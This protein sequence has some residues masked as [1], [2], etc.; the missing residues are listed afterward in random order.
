MKIRELFANI[1]QMRPNAFT[2]REKLYFLNT[3]EGRI[4]KEILQKAEGD[5]SVFQVFQE[6]EEEREL[7]VPIPY[8]DIYLYYLAAMIDFYNGDSSRYN[9]TMVLYN[10]AWEDFA[11]YYRQTHKPK[12]INLT[13]MMPRRR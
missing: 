6:G 8:T 3:I 1:D 12:Q 13:G 7:I 5:D 4:Y 10:Q 9:D 11:A 2:D